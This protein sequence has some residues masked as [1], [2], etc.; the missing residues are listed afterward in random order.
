MAAISIRNLVK[1]YANVTVIPDLNLEIDFVGLELDERIAGRDRLAFLAQPLGDTGI[2][3]GF[4]DFGNDDVCGH[5]C[6]GCQLPVTGCQEP[7]ASRSRQ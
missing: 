6:F 5:R 2:D 4:T 1:R 3:D 7:V